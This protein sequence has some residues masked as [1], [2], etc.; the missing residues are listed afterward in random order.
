MIEEYR[1]PE[2]TRTSDLYRVTTARRAVSYC[3]AIVTG[4]LVCPAMLNTTGTALPDCTPE[5]TTALTWY[6]SGYPG[7]SP[8]KFTCAATPPIVTVSGFSVY[9]NGP[10][11][12]AGVPDGTAGFTAPN[13]LQ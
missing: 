3:T 6:R 7:A 11:T 4:G 12:G 1:G 13:P 2:R 9:D 8:A 10:P 5:G